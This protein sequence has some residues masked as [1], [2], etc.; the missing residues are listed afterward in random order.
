MSQGVSLTILSLK[1]KKMLIVG[2]K[3]RKWQ[4]LTYRTRKRNM[5]KR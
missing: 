1:K 3:H 2:A 5:G 4:L